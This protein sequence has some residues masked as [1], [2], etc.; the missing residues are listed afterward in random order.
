MAPIPTFRARRAVIAALTLALSTQAH[1]WWFGGRKE[2][3]I[4]PYIG[5]A[6]ADRVFVGGRVLKKRETSDDETAF[7]ANVKRFWTHEVSG[8]TVQILF[9]GRAA[10]AR[11]DGEGFYRAQIKRR[12]IQTPQDGFLTV[13]CQLTPHRKYTAAP[14]YC[15]VV[16]LGPRARIGVISDIDDTVVRMD[17]KDKTAMLKRVLFGSAETR[18]VFR[19]V[20]ILYQ[21]LRQGAAGGERNPFFYVSGSPHNLYDLIVATFERNDVPPGF[22]ALKDLGVGPEADPLREQK[23]YKR[24]RILEI[25]GRF[26]NLTFICIGDSNEKDAEIYARLATK[27]AH[28]D[29]I[30]AVYIRDLADVEDHKR[31]KAL[32]ALRRQVGTDR[33]VLAG[34]TFDMAEHAQRHGWLS[35]RVR[36]RAF[37]VLRVDGSLPGHEGKGTRYPIVLVHGLLGFGQLGIG[38]ENAKYYFKGVRED[39]TRLGYS[40]FLTKVGDR[41]GVAVRAA[42]LKRRINRITSGKVNIIAHSMGGLDA[43]YMIAH[44]DMANRVA[45]LTMISTPHRG[46]AYADWGVEHVGGALKLFKTL[47]IEIQAL[48]D[49]TTD[50]CKKLNETTP[51]SPGVKYISYSGSQPHKKICTYLRSAHKVI[52][53]AEG[54]NDG[55]VS[56]RSAKWGEY[57]GNLAADHLNQI[58]RKGPLERKET[59]DG[60]AFYRKLAA[61]LKREGF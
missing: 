19:G 3:E 32:E 53:K 58:C 12:N 17:V 34:N 26:P 55:L 29:R 43:R 7:S 6:N 49:L 30:A 41:D 37:A 22:F 39:L 51:D 20:S 10:V 42:Q 28:R 31:L 60:P 61:D 38:R 56:V 15:K 57:R 47:G 8:V 54:P 40:V 11:T 36:D 9:E 52:L 2:L 33:F 48:Y 23:A 45:S 18:E 46:S 1:A 13:R 5:Y 21:G 4:V 24:R 14:A 44:L 59:F 16:A 35:T 50:A 25:L 27:P